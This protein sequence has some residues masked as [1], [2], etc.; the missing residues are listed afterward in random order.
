MILASLV[1]WIQ[2]D[3]IPTGFLEAFLGVYL[4]LAVAGWIF[5]GL[6]LMKI[7]EKTNT[8]NGWWGFVPILNMVLLIQISGKPIWW[9]LLL[10]IPLA[11]I[12]I[13][14]MIFMGVAEARGKPGW[15]GLLMLVPVVNIAVLAILAFGD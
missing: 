12:V 3:S 4:V 8:P 7:A 13:V 11:N 15:W 1:A 2:Q 6:C 14:V 10:F 9:I 5:T